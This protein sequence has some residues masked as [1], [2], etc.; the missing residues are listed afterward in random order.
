MVLLKNED[1]TL[2][3]SKTDFTSTSSLALVGPQSD[4]W[5]VLLGAVNYAFE[6]GPSKGYVALRCAALRCAAL[7]CVAL[8]TSLP[9][10]PA[11]TARTASRHSTAA[12]S[13]CSH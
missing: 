4:D 7:R 12:S 8:G 13:Y 6:D 9:A 3:L 5:R 1:S 11:S 10:L 2:P